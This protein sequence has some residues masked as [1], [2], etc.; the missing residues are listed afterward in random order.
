MLRKMMPRKRELSDSC[1][2]ISN[3]KKLKREKREAPAYKYSQPRWMASEGLSQVKMHRSASNKP[4]GY[5]EK[6]SDVWAEASLFA[7]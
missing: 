1:T 2:N 4:L 7:Y 3:T 5:W 6:A